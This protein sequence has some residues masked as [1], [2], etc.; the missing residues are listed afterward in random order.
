MAETKKASAR[1][2]TTTGSA[3]SSIDAKGRNDVRQQNAMLVSQR[4]TA[5]NAGTSISFGSEQI[6]YTSNTKEQLGRS[7]VGLDAKEYA[8]TQSKIKSIKAELSQSACVF[9]D[10]SETTSYNTT[11]R[12]ALQESANV[13]GSKGSR[14][15]PKEISSGSTIFF[16]S[17]PCDYV[18]ETKRASTALEGDANEYKSRRAEVTAMKQSLLRRNFSLGEEPV[19]YLSDYQRGFSALPPDTYKGSKRQEMKEFLDDTRR[20]HFILGQDQ[21]DYRSNTEMALTKGMGGS[22]EDAA[23]QIQQAKALKLKLQKTSFV[24]GDDEEFA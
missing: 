20:C 16:G 15:K 11:T 13:A 4:K 12:S 3:L 6:Q 18:T 19:E 24:I 22:S 1:W 14:S 2:Q 7:V 10:A 5:K 23:K 9:G 17:T 8:A 21:V